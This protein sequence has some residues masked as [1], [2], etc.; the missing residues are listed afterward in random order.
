M[1]DVLDLGTLDD[2]GR[3]ALERL[4]LTLAEAAAGTAA[5]ELALEAQAGRAEQTRLFRIVRDY[6][7]T[8]RAEA[9]A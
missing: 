9:P 2:A 3:A 1:S 5:H 6:T 7:M 8:A 4:I